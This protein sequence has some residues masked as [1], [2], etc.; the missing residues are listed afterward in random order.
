VEAY[1]RGGAREVMIVG[2]QGNV[3]FF[4][5]EGQRARSALGVVLDLPRELF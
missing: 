2:M 3:D 1:L 5:P 4:S